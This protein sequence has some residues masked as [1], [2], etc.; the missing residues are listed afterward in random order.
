MKTTKEMIDVMQAYE[1]GEKI[2]FFNYDYGQWKDVDNPIWDWLHNDYRVKP[3]SKYVPFETAEEFL[4]AQRDNGY[5]VS[6]KGKLLEAYINGRDTVIISDPYSR[7]SELISLSDLFRNYG[8]K[9]GTPCGKEV[10]A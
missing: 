9:D 5:L 3:K 7:V 6:N 10:K 4:V 1:R 2:E 8:F